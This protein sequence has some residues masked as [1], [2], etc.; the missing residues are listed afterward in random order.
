MK[1]CI[2]CNEDEEVQRCHNCDELFCDECIFRNG[3]KCPQCGSS[4]QARASCSVT[5]GCGSGSQEEP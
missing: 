3:M 5:G 1:M 2:S 4:M